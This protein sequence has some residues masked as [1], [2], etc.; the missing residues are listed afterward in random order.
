MLGLAVLSPDAYIAKQNVER[1]Q[2]DVAYLIMLSDDA[3]PALTA[4]SFRLP[5]PPYTNVPDVLKYRTERLGSSESLLTW[6]L[7][8]ARTRAA[9]ASFWAK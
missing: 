5:N 9:L 4:A 3:L 1:E 7:G 8:R 2:V 6:N